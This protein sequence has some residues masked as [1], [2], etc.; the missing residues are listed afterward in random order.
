MSFRSFDSIAYFC[1]GL[2]TLVMMKEHGEKNVFDS[3]AEIF[4]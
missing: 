3:V 2:G 1:Q 4:D